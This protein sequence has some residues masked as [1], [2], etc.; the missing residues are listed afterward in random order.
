MKRPTW[1]ERTAAARDMETHR[2]ATRKAAA[3]LVDVHGRVPTTMMTVARA[4]RV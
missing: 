1:K 4:R 3:G 2:K